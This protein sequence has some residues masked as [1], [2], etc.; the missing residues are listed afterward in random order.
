MNSHSR[1]YS[2]VKV[3]NKEARVCELIDEETRQWKV[4]LVN[5]IFSME[6]AE[7]IRNIP[8]NMTVA[9]DIKI[10]G[11]SEKCIFSVKNAYHVELKRERIVNGGVIELS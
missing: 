3:L 11:T 9:E 10:C 6:E 1:I 2:S 5:E 8:L 7:A 4:S